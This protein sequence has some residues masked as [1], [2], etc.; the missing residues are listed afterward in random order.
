MRWP[1]RLSNGG[2]FLTGGGQG[3]ARGL[4]LGWVRVPEGVAGL[5]SPGRDRSW[6]GVSGVRGRGPGSGQG[7]GGAELGGAGVLGSQ[8]AVPGSKVR[9]RGA[10][11]ASKGSEALVLHQTVPQRLPGGQKPPRLA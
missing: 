6:G 9:S 1:G 7:P 5:L 2:I 11:R 8:G 4:G 10:G 3:S